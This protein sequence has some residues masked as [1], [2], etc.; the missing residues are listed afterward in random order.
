M[1]VAVALSITVIATT[2]PSRLPLPSSLRR[3][4]P[5]P[6]CSP[7]TLLPSCCHHPFCCHRVTIAPSINVAVA[8]APSI[9]FVAA[10]SPSRLCHRCRCAVNCCCCCAVH[11]RCRH[12]RLSTSL[13]LCCRSTFYCCCGTRL[14]HNG[15]RCCAVHQ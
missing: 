15:R 4:L 12:C 2:L 9:D 5:L 11:C 7:S 1:A 10:A 14:S 8:V 13:P 6:T 3:L